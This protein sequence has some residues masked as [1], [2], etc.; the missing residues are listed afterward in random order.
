MNLDHLRRLLVQNLGVPAESADISKWYLNID[1]YEVT[2]ISLGWPAYGMVCTAS[3]YCKAVHRLTQEAV[4]VRKVWEGDEL[5]YR[6]EV[7]NMASVNHP[8]ILPLIGCTPFSEESDPLGMIVTPMME[9]GT[10]FGILEKVRAGQPPAWWSA[11]AKLKILLGT[12]IAGKVLHEHRMLYRDLKPHN[13]LLDR[14]CEPKLCNCGASIYHPPPDQIAFPPAV[15]TPMYQAPEVLRTEP[16]GFPADVFAFGM[17]M[18]SVWTGQNPFSAPPNSR[19]PL[20]ALMVYKSIL[21]GSR[22]VFPPGTPEL[23][24]TLAEQCWDADRALRPEIG[25]V[26]EDLQNPSLLASIDDL[27]ERDLGKYLDKLLL[28]R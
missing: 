14:D 3:P 27:S 1:D 28:S 8:A 5:S 17:L 24:K 16:Y 18:Y 13:I 6:R 23:L 22:P 11:T 26:V 10:L 7:L 20:S 19:K 4:A 12:A 9:T 2:G 15:G 25:K 21:S